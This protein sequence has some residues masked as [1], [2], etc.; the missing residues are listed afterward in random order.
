[1]TNRSLRVETGVTIE[2]NDAGECI[3][4]RLDDNSFTDRFYDILDTMEKTSVLLDEAE[5]NGKDEREQLTIVTD[6]IK[7]VMQDIDNLFGA[8]ACKKVFGDIIPSGYAIADFFDQLLPIFEEYA[9]E[10]QQK[11]LSKYSNKR[12]GARRG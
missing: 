3:V 9:N 5:E 8:D 1:M 2:V 12:K 11:I 7:K 4:A 10:K 6:R